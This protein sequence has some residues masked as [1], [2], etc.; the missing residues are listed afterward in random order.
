MKRLFPAA[1]ALLLALA[2][3]CS[4]LHHKDKKA[5]QPELPPS[6]GIEAEFR[7]RWMNK[8]VH[9]LL[10]AGAAATEDQARQM[11]AAEFATQYPYLIPVN[12]GA[13]H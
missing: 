13:R 10:A 5:R 8:R 4:L 7:D 1:L 9:E 6:A 11:A 12:P 2:S 3:G